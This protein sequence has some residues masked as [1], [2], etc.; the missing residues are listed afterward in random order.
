MVASFEPLP[1]IGVGSS[2]GNAWRQLWPNFLM[3]FLIGIIAGLIGIGASVLDAVS[4][5]GGQIGE[6]G[7]GAGVAIA[8]FAGLLSL[9][10]GLLI[11]GPIEFGVAFAY[12]K[13]GG[14]L[15]LRET[16]R[17]EE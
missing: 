4:E 7:N 9:A 12:L 6:S 17:G 16:L 14:Y 2:Y 3:L 8:I 5:Y 13:A 10:Y 11:T 1:E 15:V